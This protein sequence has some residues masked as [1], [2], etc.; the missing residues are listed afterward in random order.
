VPLHGLAAAAARHLEARAGFFAVRDLDLAP[1]VHA[2]PPFAAP[3]S[4]TSTPWK[5]RPCRSGKRGSR[6]GVLRD[7]ETRNPESRIPKGPPG[8]LYGRTT[9]RML[10]AT[11]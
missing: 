1:A 2:T 9:I 4:H 3:H 11:D 8:G 6:G 7:V 10:V 5:V